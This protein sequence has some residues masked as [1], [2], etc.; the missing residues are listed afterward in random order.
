MNS[1]IDSNRPWCCE[2][3]LITKANE[4]NFRQVAA[5]PKGKV[6]RI[7]CLQI[8]CL[9]T[10][11]F[12][13]ATA[14][15]RRSISICLSCC[16]ISY[17]DLLVWYVRGMRV[18]ACSFRWLCSSAV[19]LVVAGPVSRS[20]VCLNS[21]DFSWSTVEFHL[22]M[23][24]HS[25]SSWVLSAAAAAGALYLYLS[26]SDAVEKYEFNPYQVQAS[27]SAT[28]TKKQQNNNIERE[29]GTSKLKIYFCSNSDDR[30]ASNSNTRWNTKKTKRRNAKNERT[31]THTRH[32]TA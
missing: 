9:S 8:V 10:L 4:W 6:N 12:L 17:L 7:S 30:N 14:A 31:H 28:T 21:R 5:T 22:Y 29:T 27:I 11:M 32:E 20:F 1:K 26:R 25:P 15:V 18:T 24:L 23:Y 13:W 16:P 2:V 19:F 3:V